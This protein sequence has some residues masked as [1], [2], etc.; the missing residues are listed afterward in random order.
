MATVNATLS[1]TGTGSPTLAQSPSII[2]STVGTSVPKLVKLPTRTLNATGTTVPKLLRLPQKLLTTSAGSSIFIAAVAF[3]IDTFD[4]FEGK[5]KWIVNGV[6]R[7]QFGT[8]K[9]FAFLVRGKPY[10]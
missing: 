2:R 8:K 10:G 1:C 6:D 3:G 4:V 5:L 7:F 9:R